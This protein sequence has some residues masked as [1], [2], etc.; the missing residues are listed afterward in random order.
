MALSGL[1][2]F[3]RSVV[4]YVPA[5]LKTRSLISYIAI[6]SILS[7]STLIYPL[8]APKLHQVGTSRTVPPILNHIVSQP[9]VT[10]IPNSTP[11]RCHHGSSTTANTAHTAP[12]RIPFHNSAGARTPI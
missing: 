6:V 10:R 2:L 8:I 7:Y 9:T 12:A 11:Q 5:A 3:D 4:G 1:Y